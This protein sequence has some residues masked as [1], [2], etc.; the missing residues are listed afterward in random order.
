M[1]LDGIDPSLYDDCA[2]WTAHPRF[3]WV[4][5]RLL[6]AETTG[7]PSGPLGVDPASGSL[8]VVVKPITNLYGMGRGARLV[9]PGDPVEY[10]PGFM[11]QQALAGRHVSVD[12]RLDPHTQAAIWQAT[13]VGTPDPVRFGR[14]ALW[15]LIPGR[16]PETDTAEAWALAHLKHYAGVLNV[17]LI[18]GQVIEVHL[19][20]TQ[21]WLEA[22]VY[23]PDD[24]V[25]PPAAVLIPE[26]SDDD[27]DGDHGRIGYTVHRLCAREVA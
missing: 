24:T 14:F 3:R 25:P 9:R 26:W 1:T 16:L 5:D 17:E 19:R 7:V 4:Y 20:L 2:A 13:S 8:P 11:W 15:E 21:D 23:G 27:E 10:Q 6:V 12:M 22:G 18:G